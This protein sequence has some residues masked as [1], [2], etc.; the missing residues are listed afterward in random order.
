MPGRI[1]ENVYFLH[2][3]CMRMSRGVEKIGV[4]RCTDWDD[5]TFLRISQSGSSSALLQAVFVISM[6][7]VI[8]F[9][10]MIFVSW[11][12]FVSSFLRGSTSLQLYESRISINLVCVLVSSVSTQYTFLAFSRRFRLRDRKK[13]SGFAR[14]P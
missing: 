4:N 2:A 5:V 1:G 14:V 11:P 12:S 6:T 10:A 13:E 3:L 8:S 7:S 9:S